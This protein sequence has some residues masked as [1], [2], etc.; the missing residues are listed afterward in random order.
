[1]QLTLDDFWDRNAYFYA[2]TLRIP[3]YFTLSLAQY[4]ITF[5][6]MRPLE[7]HIALIRSDKA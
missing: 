2:M 5:L 7:K 1:M 3:N 4:N 6:D